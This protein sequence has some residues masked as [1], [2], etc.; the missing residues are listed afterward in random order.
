M[1]QWVQNVDWIDTQETARDRVYDFHVKPGLPRAQRI[2]ASDTNVN[3]DEREVDIAVTFGPWDIALVV[4]SGNRTLT[5]INTPACIG[6]A[7][8]LLLVVLDH[9]LHLRSDF[10]QPLF[11][12]LR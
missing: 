4:I 8:E 5:K 9:D 2:Q 6:Q 10:K 11:A 12:C 1:V 7:F 3:P